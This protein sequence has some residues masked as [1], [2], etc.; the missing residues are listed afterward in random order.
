MTPVPADGL[1]TVAG[2]GL[3]A[4]VNPSRG[5]KIVSLTD[6][7][8]YQWLLPPDDGERAGRA[9]AFTDAEMGGWDECAPSII[10]CPAPD[11]TMIP[12]HGDLW[13]A[14]WSAEDACVRIQGSSLPYTLSRTHLSTAGGLRLEY[15][16]TASAAV[17]WLWAAHPQFAAPPGTRVLIDASTVV[18]VHDPSAPRL[19]W[20]DE[21]SCIDTVAAGGCRKLYLDPSEQCGQVTLA[22]PGQGRLQ[23]RWD[24]SVAPYLGLWFDAG[25]YARAPAIALEP[26]TGYYDSLTTAIAHKRILTLNP[27]RPVRWF[28]EVT[29]Q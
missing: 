6:R 16:V 8:G 12:D 18:D 3:T 19:A 2:D 29:V 21:L 22:V 5:A 10:A 14:G 28:V 11:G 13:N 1:L 27:D 25:A 17:P 7:A 20:S 4:V 9:V 24:A 15:E 26:S 23:L